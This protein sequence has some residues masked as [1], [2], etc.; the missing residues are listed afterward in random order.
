MLH[1]VSGPQS[2]LKIV[3]NHHVHSPASLAS[4]LPPASIEVFE[5]GGVLKLG[6]LC[7]GGSG[8]GTEGA[9]GAEGAEGAEWLHGDVLTIDA[10]TAP[11]LRAPCAPCSTSCSA[12]SWRPS[13][14]VAGAELHRAVDAGLGAEACANSHTNLGL[15]DVAFLLLSSNSV[16]RLYS[17]VLRPG[18]STRPH[19]I[20]T[21][22]VAIFLSAG[23]LRARHM[24]RP[25]PIKWPEYGQGSHGRESPM[26]NKK[27][28]LLV[29][30]LRHT[31][32]LDDDEEE[33]EADEEEEVGQVVKKACRDLLSSPGAGAKEGK[34]EKE[35]ARTLRQAVLSSLAGPHGC[36]S[37][38]SG[39]GEGEE[40]TL[41]EREHSRRQ[42]KRLEEV[43][44]CVFV[45]VCRSTD[46][47]DV[48]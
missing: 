19:T 44:V 38:G 27:P 11:R 2:S 47:Q 21:P 34:A 18:E 12:H 39:E 42:V 10:K 9:G 45:C 13:R 14:D 22:G 23:Q 20:V 37:R 48:H 28:R 7:G 26:P 1:L 36:T 40:E 8:G 25:L 5:R 33:E 16:Y 6:P 29:S 46:C 3:A 35:A 15:D 32:P 24:S 4:S 30:P 43:H 41:R 31:S 17:M